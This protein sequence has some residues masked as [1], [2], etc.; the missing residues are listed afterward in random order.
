MV[1]ST[2]KEQRKIWCMNL[3]GASE[4]ITQLQCVSKVIGTLK[5]RI[6]DTY[7]NLSTRETRLGKFWK[8]TQQSDR[9]S[10]TCK[11]VIIITR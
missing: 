3:V 2:I 6:F 11:I 8:L 10:H 4:Y 1:A 7:L 5:G 9:Q